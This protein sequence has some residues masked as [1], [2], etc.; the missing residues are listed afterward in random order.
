[1]AAY[2]WTAYISPTFA[3]TLLGK[4]SLQDFERMYDSPINGRDSETNSKMAGFYVQHNASI[5][6]QCFAAGMLLGVGGLFTTISNAAILGGVF[7]YMATLDVRENFFN[8]VT[9]HGPFELT[10]IV[11]GA[12][13]G[14]RLGFSLI[15][16]HGYTR[17]ESLRRA[18]H[19]AIAPASVSVIL[20]CLAAVI[21]GFV[22][23]SGLP[24]WVK[25]S[26]ALVST[27]I[28]LVYLLVLGYSPEA[29]DAA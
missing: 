1:M 6:L 29:P 12:A 21:E 9:A 4:E 2:G 3:E 23:P 26:V 16:T 28:L 17:R 10:A 19:Q 13:A 8:F 5:G 20:F 22:S 15:D 27:I 14:M 24:Y 7:G 11:L 25:A 18:A